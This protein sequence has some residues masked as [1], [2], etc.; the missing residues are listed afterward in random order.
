VG[1]FNHRHMLKEEGGISWLPTMSQSTHVA[2]SGATTGQSYWGT[3]H[4]CSATTP[5]CT[6]DEEQD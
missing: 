6:V 2:L 1:G 3:E 4:R 5:L